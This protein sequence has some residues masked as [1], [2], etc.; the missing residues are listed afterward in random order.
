M[1]ILVIDKVIETR[2]IVDIID[3][4]ALK[5]EFLNREAGF[6]VILS[7]GDKLKFSEDIP[8]ESTAFAIGCKKEKWNEFKN[9]VVAQWQLD[10]TDYP[11]F[12]I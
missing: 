1:K 12:K 3:V 11:T 8:Y 9:R 5:T 6:F 2:D 7:N 4:E 10:K